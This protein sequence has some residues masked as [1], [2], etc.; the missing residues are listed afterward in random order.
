MGATDT[1]SGGWTLV[2]EYAHEQQ[3]RGLKPWGAAFFHHQDI[4][5]AL[6]GSPLY[7]AFGE[8]NDNEDEEFR[9]PEKD[10]VV[11]R[12]VVEALRKHGFEPDWEGS[13]S[14]RIQVLPGFTWRRRRS[15]LDTSEELHM[16]VF[17]PGLAELLP[18]LRTLWLRA[19]NVIVYDLDALRSNSLEELTVEFWDDDDAREAQPDLVERVRGR[20]PRLRTFTVKGR[21]FEETVHLGG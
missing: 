4:E 1:L 5:H 8:L 21:G 14:S 12:A 15:H 19:E 18:R 17:V 11:A 7:L 13:A 20:F 16:G 9:N 3:R 10:V 2:T 6:E